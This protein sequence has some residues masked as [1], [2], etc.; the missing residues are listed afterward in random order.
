MKLQS[1]KELQDSIEYELG[2]LQC[3]E[4]CIERG[5]TIN[6]WIQCKSD[7]LN[8]MRYRLNKL[9]QIER[10]RDGEAESI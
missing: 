9:I 1:I 3:L 4:A 5:F 2:D 8:F 6:D 10:G 7:T